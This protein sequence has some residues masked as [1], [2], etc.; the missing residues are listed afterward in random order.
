MVNAR[1]VVKDQALNTIGEAVTDQTGLVTVKPCD[2]TGPI[3]LEVHGGDGAKYYDEALGET[4]DLPAG[5]VLNLIVPT[6]GGNMVASTHTTA[7]AQLLNIAGANGTS[8]G[9][10]TTALNAQAI[11]DANRRV[12]SLLDSHLPGIHR[13]TASDSMTRLPVLLDDNNGTQVN[14]LPDT[15]RGRYAATLAGF[16]KA[17]RGFQP[18]DRGAMLKFHRQMS[19]D[20]SD[21]RLDLR[22]NGI[23]VAS[24]TEITY[25]YD[26]LWLSMT[27]G[28]G[29]TSASIGDAAMRA[30]VVPISRSFIQY[31]RIPL[32]FALTSD[33]RL[34]FTYTDERGVQSTRPVDGSYLELNAYAGHAVALSS[35]R[36]YVR[37]A[38]NAWT[39]GPPEA[40]PAT[41]YTWIS[42]DED[43]RQLLQRTDKPANRLLARLSNGAFYMNSDLTYSPGIWTKLPYPTNV[44]S[45]YWG[46]RNRVY[47]LTTEGRILQWPEHDSVSGQSELA[48]NGVL[49]LT[50]HAEHGM[51]LALTA[52]GQVYWVNRNEIPLVS[53]NQFAPGSTSGSIAYANA[54]AAPLAL[55]G[56]P[57]GGIC[58]ISG[59]YLVGCDGSAYKV[60]T[61]FAVL[62]APECR[63]WV[64][65]ITGVTRINFPAG[66][67]IWRVTTQKVPA[68]K[69][70]TCNGVEITGEVPTFFTESGVTFELS[71]NQVPTPVLVPAITPALTT[72]IPRPDEGLMNFV[73]CAD[74]QKAPEFLGTFQGTWNP[75]NK[76]ACR[77]SFDT[78]G[79]AVMDAPDGKRLTTRFD[80]DEFDQIR[81][82][83]HPVHGDASYLTATNTPKRDTGP[84]IMFSQN[85]QTKRFE[86]N[87][88]LNGVWQFE[89]NQ[90]CD[91]VRGC[92]N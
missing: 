51:V 46:F 90:A 77:F 10:P 67:K 88:W 7:S 84:R 85:L 53:G 52:E 13:L 71:A 33:G 29:S 45:I 63:S 57:T 73:Y 54:A 86:A 49:Q 18:N 25:T 6:I 58:W 72:C 61:S 21:G 43:Y 80:G 15:D 40:E 16:A 26:S 5:T 66:E 59:S 19:D 32:S 2:Y 31:G 23:P 83:R 41:S 9:S 4:S 70:T 62:G 87:Y 34:Q 8:S 36:K 92:G 3:L 39:L 68:Y 50:N 14:T 78:A 37:M 89:C 76:V 27:V 38:S 44:L 30:K 65:A 79:N 55:S 28:A 24:P 11:G 56:L 82:W 64:T 35:D 22:K 91:I 20:L 81:Y 17:A 12:L 47:G 60:Q 42:Q 1:V 48:I 75:D 69:A 74:T